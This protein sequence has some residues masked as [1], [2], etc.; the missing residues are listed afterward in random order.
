MPIN[1]P[2]AFP[3]YDD[4]ANCRFRSGD[5][6]WWNTKLPIKLSSILTIEERLSR[7][8]DLQPYQR[9]EPSVEII[10]TPG[11]EEINNQIVNANKLANETR[12]ALTKH[13]SYKKRKSYK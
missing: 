1:C 11:Y 9:K 13:I 3:K 7:L 8:E 4:C 2:N 6:C 10:H 5:E 12:D